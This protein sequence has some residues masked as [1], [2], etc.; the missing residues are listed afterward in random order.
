MAGKLKPTA[1]DAV[2]VD[3]HADGRQ[4]EA[5][6]HREVGGLASDTRQLAQFLHCVRQ[7]AAEAFAQ[8]GGKGVQ[9]AGLVVVEAD[10]E[11]EFLEFRD[12]NR[13]EGVGRG[14]TAHASEETLDGACGTLVL[15]AGGE[16][17]THEDA[18]RIMRLR[19]D[20]LDDGRGVRLE[21]LLEQAVHL[22]YVFKRHSAL[23]FFRVFDAL[24]YTTFTARAPQIRAFPL[25]TGRRNVV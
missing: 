10:G 22:R 16:D 25:C 9:V 7:H 13:L 21:L 1:R 3:V 8:D 14:G 17:R 19:L 20:Q 6:G 24:Q 15:R 23:S 18:E 12:G 4:V 5:H 11:D 2:D